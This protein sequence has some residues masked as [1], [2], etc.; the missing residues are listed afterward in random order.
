MQLLIV[1]RDAALV[2]TI[3][4]SWHSALIEAVTHQKEQRLA[5]DLRRHA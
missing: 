2:E 4:A 1:H 3:P 5:G